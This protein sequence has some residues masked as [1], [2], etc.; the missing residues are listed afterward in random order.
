MP[1]LPNEV[2]QEQRGTP[3]LTLL[4]IAKKDNEDKAGPNSTPSY[5]QNIR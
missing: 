5:L 2:K 4:E 3:S 1:M